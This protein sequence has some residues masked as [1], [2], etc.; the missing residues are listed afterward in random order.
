MIPPACGSL[1]VWV[2][3]LA[4]LVTVR[5]AAAQIPVPDAAGQIPAPDQEPLPEPTG[6]IGPATADSQRPGVT[7]TVQTQRLDLGFSFYGALDQTS[8]T[9]VR[10]VFSSEPLLDDR[11]GFGGG[12]A[13]LTY[14]YAGKENTFAAVGG[15]GLRNYTATTTSVFYPSDVYGGLTFSRR[16][17]RRVR[18]TGREIVTFTPYYSFGMSQ[19]TGGFT[20]LVPSLSATPQLT[21]PGVAPQFDQAINRVNS[22][23]TDTTVGVT[24]TLNQKSSVTAGYSYY[25]TD[26][27]ADAASSYRVNNMGANGSYQYRKSRYMTLHFGYGFYRNQLPGL[28]Q[29]PGLIVPYYDEHNLDLGIGYRRPLSFS[30]RSILS[31]NLG[32]TMITNGV[33]HYF[34]VTGDAG[35]T[36]QLSQFW[37]LGVSYNRGVSRSGGLAAPFVSDVGALSVGGLL[38]RRL[39]VAGIG[40]FSRGNTAVGTSNAYDAA[41]TTGRLTYELTRFLPVYTEYIYYFYRFSTSNGLAG[42][43]PMNINRNGVRLGLAYSIPLI[44]RRPQRR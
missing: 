17:S 18:L 34:Y 22:L 3:V 23:T 37:T 30:R 10:H 9:D 41:Y 19:P 31:F 25:H 44:G 7:P 2:V 28:N 38:T 12:T 5:P 32:S 4:L 16:L 20:D 1:R 42:N 8:V 27:A 14:T 15:S 29:F 43:F 24:W 36:H 6:P 33:S 26:S 13:N 40:S 21:S 35:L 11:V 39:S